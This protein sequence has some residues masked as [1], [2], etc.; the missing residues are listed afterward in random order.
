MT[1]EFGH[2]HGIAGT[3][4]NGDTRFINA[5]YLN[6]RSRAAEPA[7]VIQIFDLQGLSNSNQHP[8]SA[9]KLLGPKR[10]TG[11]ANLDGQFE[12]IF[13]L[14]RF[15]LDDFEVVGC[16]GLKERKEALRINR[17]LLAHFGVRDFVKIN[18]WEVKSI[19]SMGQSK[20]FDRGQKLFVSIF[21]E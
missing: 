9:T 5:A 21:I 17:Q 1:A 19:Q 15:L 3:F 6:Q 18:V 11:Q 4:E 13:A 7:G 20:R 2:I 14:D 10:S 12:S 16:K 8:E